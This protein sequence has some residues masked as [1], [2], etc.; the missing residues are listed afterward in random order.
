[1]RCLPPVDALLYRLSYVGA[2]SLMIL[3]AAAGARS[4]HFRPMAPMA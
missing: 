4:F 2:I 3:A 1:M